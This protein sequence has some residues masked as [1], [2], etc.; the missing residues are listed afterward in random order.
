MRYH[1]LCVIFLGAS[2]VV[3]D[4]QRLIQYLNISDIR[5][6]NGSSPF[7]GRVEIQING[8]WGTVCD[9]SFTRNVADVMCRMMNLSASAYLVGGRYGPGRGP[10][11]AQS[12]SCSSNAGHLRECQYTTNAIC[13]HSKD[14]GII[15]SVCGFSTL[16]SSYITSF[17]GTIL[18]ARCPTNNYGT[19]KAQC[20]SN[21][22]WLLDDKCSFQ[23]SVIGGVRLEGSN[24]PNRGRVEVK[25]NGT[26]GTVC[27]NAFD[28][29]DARVI[30]EM[31]GLAL[32]LYLIGTGVQNCR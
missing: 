25:V 7:E 11:F 16:E 17:N 15:C 26:W 28:S 1:I 9:Q 22:T 3:T 10:I 30:C 13:T 6:E 20:L 31:L 18:T 2:V 5:L 23:E 14:I 12:F 21:R 4:A 29:D 19:I 8:V 32:V 27:D 24:I